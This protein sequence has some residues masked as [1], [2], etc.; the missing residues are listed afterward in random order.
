[1]VYSTVRQA[2][3]GLDLFAKT[4]MHPFDRLTEEEYNNYSD[5]EL[6]EAIYNRFGIFGGERPTE[7]LCQR[8]ND[9]LLNNKPTWLDSEKIED[10][11]LSVVEDGYV[12]PDNEIRKRKRNR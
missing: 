7:R 3:S 1:M 6:L 5:S 4:D 11:E 2:L 9:A 10:T 12:L 8:I